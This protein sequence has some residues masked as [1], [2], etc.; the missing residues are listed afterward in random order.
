M[1]N[2]VE[3][4]FLGEDIESEIDEEMGS[5]ENNRETSVSKYIDSNSENV[6]SLEDYSNWD[7]IIDNIIEDKYKYFCNILKDHSKR[8]PDYAYT[9]IV[10]N[11]KCISTLII[12]VEENIIIMPENLGYET[13]QMCEKQ[14]WKIFSIDKVEENLDLIGDAKNG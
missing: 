11:K 2:F 13:I 5:N 4:Y 9:D 8:K 12:Y 1:W 7:M 10:I 14:G 6:Y 3:R